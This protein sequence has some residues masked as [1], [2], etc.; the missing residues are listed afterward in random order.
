M[1]L[2]FSAYWPKAATSDACPWAELDLWCVFRALC[3]QE[4]SSSWLS[5]WCFQ[6]AVSCTV[7]VL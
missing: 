2:S 7:T 5:L 3:L 4:E 6:A 1:S